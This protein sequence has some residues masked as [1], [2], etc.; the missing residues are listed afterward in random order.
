MKKI[1]L[2]LLCVALLCSHCIYTHA[3]ETT[4]ESAVVLDAA[5]GVVMYAK[6]ETMR[7]SMASTTKIMSALIVLE[8]GDLD[9][10]YRVSKADACVEGSSLGLHEGDV[11]RVRSLLYGLMIVS[12]NDAAHALA[13]AVC[14]NQKAFVRRMNQKAAALGLKNTHFTNPAG[15]T[16]QNHYSTAKDMALL[17]AYALKDARFREICAQSEADISFETPKKSVTLYNHNRLLH[18]YEGCIGIKTGYTMDAGRCLVSAARRHGQI[19]IA[20][21]LGDVNDWAD[22]KKMLDA[23][24]AASVPYTFDLRQ[25]EIP[26]V[27]SNRQSVSPAQSKICLYV[28]KS[29]LPAIRAQVCAPHFLYAPVGKGQQIATVSICMG[30]KTLKSVV[31]SSAQTAKRQV[32]QKQSIFEKLFH[33]G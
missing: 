25:I 6:N 21:T 32:I 12:G 17:S 5:T 8:Y 2:L 9:A 4:A 28:P 11:L 27:G 13:N 30:H 19:L 3:L 14:G 20:V 18:E 24:F 7:R 10:C 15:L 23:G 26:V 29:V 1:W 16:H 33:Y 31:L 22:H